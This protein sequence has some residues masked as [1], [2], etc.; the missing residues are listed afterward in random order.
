MRLVFMGK[1]ERSVYICFAFIAL[2]TL[3]MK[4][5]FLTHF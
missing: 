5:T 3:I 2:R 1:R 4:S